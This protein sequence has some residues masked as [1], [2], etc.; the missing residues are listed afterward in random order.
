[1]TIQDEMQKLGPEV[2]VRPEIRALITRGSVTPEELA[3]LRCNSWEWEA[4]VPAMNNDALLGRMEHALKNCSVDKAR[5]FATYNES[6][7]G[8]FAPELMKRFA[9]AARA[10]RDYGESLDCVR[11]ALGLG[12]T[13]YLV[14]GDD[15]KELV[16]AV[17]S[18]SDAM[19]VLNR[20]RERSK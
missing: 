18:R 8:Q 4:L 6:V 7:V 12:S 19:K 11:Q 20:I 10:A 2:H 17:E 9:S 3:E 13:H 1:M 16:E 15:V 14:I 5:P